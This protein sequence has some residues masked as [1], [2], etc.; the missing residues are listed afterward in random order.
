[1][2]SPAI[3]LPT[4]ATVTLAPPRPPGL[5]F[6]PP[7]GSTLTVFPSPGSRGQAGAAGD[8]A[9]VIGETPAGDRDGINVTFT[10]SS[11]FRTASV[12]LYLNG[13]R[14]FHFTE[15]GPDQITLEDPPINGDDLRADYVI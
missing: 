10:T 14:E 5:T 2:T 8:G 7:V 1:M 4:G 12:A 13:L 9:Q 15:T 3:P 6:G 11:P